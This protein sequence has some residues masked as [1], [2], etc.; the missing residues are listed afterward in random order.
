[1]KKK[2]KSENESDSLEET[3][4]ISNIPAILTLSDDVLLMI[5]SRLNHIDLISI[6]L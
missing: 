6:G 5:M 2:Q 4:N 1:M 3:N